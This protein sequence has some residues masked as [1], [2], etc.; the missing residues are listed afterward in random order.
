[1]PYPPTIYRY[2]IGQDQTALSMSMNVISAFLSKNAY[3]RSRTLIRRSW[4][5]HRVKPFIWFDKIEKKQMQKK[6][7]WKEEKKRLWPRGATTECVFVFDCF[8]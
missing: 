2:C 3:A 6:K 5:G 7:K 4:L 8:K 1:M